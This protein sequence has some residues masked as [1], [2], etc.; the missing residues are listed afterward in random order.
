MKTFIIATGLALF[1]GCGPSNAVTRGTGSKEP[2]LPGKCSSCHPTPE[3][4]SLDAES[5]DRILQRHLNARR[6]RLAPEERSAVQA[7]LVKPAQ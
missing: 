4:A 1:L 3:R 2:S 7:Y 5:F 6:V